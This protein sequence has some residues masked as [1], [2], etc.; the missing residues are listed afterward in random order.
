MTHEKPQQIDPTQVSKNLET[1]PSET[2]EW[3]EQFGDCYEYWEMLPE[4][5]WDY[6]YWGLV[7]R[8]LTTAKPLQTLKI[9]F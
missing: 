7:K 6:L 3:W 5:E 1:P 2:T 4:S 8:K 9:R